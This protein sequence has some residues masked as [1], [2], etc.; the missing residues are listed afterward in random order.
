[1]IPGGNKR[2]FFT[3]ASRKKNFISS[4]DLYTLNIEHNIISNFSHT[5][6]KNNVGASTYWNFKIQ[7]NDSNIMEIWYCSP[8]GHKILK[9]EVG[10]NKFRSQRVWCSLDN[11]VSC[12]NLP[13]GIM[14]KNVSIKIII[15]AGTEICGPRIKCAILWGCFLYVSPSNG[16]SSNWKMSRHNSRKKWSEV[17]HSYSLWWL[18]WTPVIDSKFI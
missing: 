13:S 1:M 4:T 5:N 8:W 16:S 3:Y 2:L 12:A 9:E 14:I 17:S 6:E 10:N 11:H 15:V 18:S 7:K